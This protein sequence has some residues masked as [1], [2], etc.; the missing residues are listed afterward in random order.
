MAIS[1][2]RRL[3]AEIISVDPFQIYRYFDLGTAKPSLEERN[4]V[5]HHLIDIYLPDERIDAYNFSKLAYQK[6]REIKER[7]KVPL[8]VGGS[9]LYW[10][11]ITDGLFEM[12]TKEGQGKIRGKLES[13]ETPVL[14]SKLKKVDREKAEMVH[15]NDRRRILRALEV[16]YLTKTPISKLQKKRN[17]SPFSFFLIGLNRIRDD[18]YQRINER[19]EALFKKGFVEE[20]QRI[21]Q[22]GYSPNL[23]PFTAIGYKEIISYLNGDLTLEKTKSLIQKETRNYARRQ[24]TWFKKDKRIQ[25]LNLKPDERPKETASR[26]LALIRKERDGD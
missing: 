21:L 24:M 9:G 26:I 23:Q 6:I 2:A 4:N 7:E 12:N 1:L 19:V 13:L 17:P 16:Y 18:L 14:Y 5:P 11:A 15:P 20:V 3:G 10:R 25:W 22:M 8:L